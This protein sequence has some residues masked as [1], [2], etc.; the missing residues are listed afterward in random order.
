MDNLI[1]LDTG[2]DRVHGFANRH[3]AFDEGKGPADGELFERFVFDCWIVE[4]VKVI[5]RPDGVA[6]VQESLAD[7][8]PDEPR[9]PCD[10]K[11][12]AGTLTN[13]GE[14]EEGV[15]ILEF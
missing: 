1:E 13:R 10:Q 11:I 12:H 14:R 9:A 3:I 15:L 7:V 8:R 6:E 4:A 2:E 5:E